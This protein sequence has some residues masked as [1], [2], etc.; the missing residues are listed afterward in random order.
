MAERLDQRGRDLLLA[1]GEPGAETARLFLFS[2]TGFSDT[3]TK[4]AE[5]DPAVQLI[6]LDRLYGGS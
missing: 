2:G 4:R 1:R 3:I 6:G 5:E